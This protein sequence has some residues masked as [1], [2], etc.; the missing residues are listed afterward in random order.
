MCSGRKSKLG[1]CLGR[2]NLVS[3]HHQYTP[4]QIVIVPRFDT[5]ILTMLTMLTP[6]SCSILRERSM[7]SLIEYHT[8]YSCI[9]YT[10][11]NFV[12]KYEYFLKSMKCCHLFVLFFKAKLSFLRGLSKLYSE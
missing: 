6:T 3:A 5:L 1:L 12:T 2:D 8:L 10:C 4:M 7:A 9:F 11:L